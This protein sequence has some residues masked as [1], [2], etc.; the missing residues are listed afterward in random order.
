MSRTPDRYPL[1]WPKHRP[2]TKAADRRRGTS[3]AGNKRITLAAAFDRLEDEIERL[4]GKNP[5]LSTN[6]EPR[7]S[8]APKA[9][10]AAPADPGVCVYFGLKGQPMTMACDTF[11]EVA[12]NIAALANHINATRRI[13]SYGVATAEEVLQNFAAL[14]PPR[15]EGI[16][17]AGASAPVPWWTFFGVMRTAADEES[18]DALYRAKARAASGDEAKLTTLNLMRDAA[19]ADIRG[20]S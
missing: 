15:A 17:P 2:R 10:V 18:I 3:S 1:A 5:I 7:I 13:A 16:V 6:I 11:T 12:Q 20:R 4:G 19:R 8:G 14:P 9:N